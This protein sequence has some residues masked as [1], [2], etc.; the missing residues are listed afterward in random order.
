MVGWSLHQIILDS[1][2]TRA[3]E[4]MV[5]CSKFSAALLSNRAVFPAIPPQIY[6]FFYNMIPKAV[7]DLPLLS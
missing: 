1:G 5:I 4:D 6:I 7:M 3:N 2:H